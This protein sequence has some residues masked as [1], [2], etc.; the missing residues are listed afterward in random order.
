MGT[1]GTNKI[2]SAKMG[3]VWYLKGKPY[4]VIA[5]NFKYMDTNG[6]PDTL[7]VALRA[8]DHADGNPDSERW[9]ITRKAFTEKASKEPPVFKEVY[10]T[11]DQILRS[12]PCKDGIGALGFALGFPNFSIYELVRALTKGGF[13]DKPY[14]V[15]EL[16]SVYKFWAKREPNTEWLLYLA[17]LLNV[18]PSQ[19]NMN[20]RAT[21]KRLLGIKE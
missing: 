10:V 18:L 19:S 3:E 7:Y 20:D 8:E 15:S 1:L 12:D 17:K 14:N 2:F 16:Y 9:I 4:V 13:L 6:D 5:T 21:L 11:P